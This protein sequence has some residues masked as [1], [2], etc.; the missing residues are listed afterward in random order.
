[1]SRT[2]SPKGNSQDTAIGVVGCLAC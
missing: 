1:M 2:C